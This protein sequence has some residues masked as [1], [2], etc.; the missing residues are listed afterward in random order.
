MNILKE[1]ENMRSDERRRLTK[2]KLSFT[3]YSREV[4]TPAIESQSDS[5]SFFSKYI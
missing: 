4:K 5:C 2:S 3:D 1:K